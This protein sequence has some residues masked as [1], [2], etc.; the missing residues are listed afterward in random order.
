MLNFYN[1]KGIIKS[2]IIPNKYSKEE[3]DWFLCILDESGVEAWQMASV[4][5][6]LLPYF[7]QETEKLYNELTGAV[8]LAI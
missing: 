6:R 1:A 4:G 2:L 5:V 7:N 3:M 8:G